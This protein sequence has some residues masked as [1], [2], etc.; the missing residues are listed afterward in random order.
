LCL[1]WAGGKH[2][3]VYPSS[4]I[5]FHGFFNGRTGEVDHA[6][7]MWDALIG[8]YLGHL[9]FDND[10]IMWM[11][12]PLMYNMHGLDD[13]TNE[14]YGFNAEYFAKEE[15][16]PPPPPV[17]PAPALSGAWRTLQYGMV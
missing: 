10:A 14:K 5:G 1:Q 9:G 3:Y 7:A 6:A 16:S 15:P 8:A 4:N 12:T 13:E 2:R 17:A 11:L